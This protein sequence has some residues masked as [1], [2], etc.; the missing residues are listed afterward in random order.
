MNLT[1]KTKKAIKN[2]IF[3]EEGLEEFKNEP[4]LFKI[5]DCIMLVVIV[6]LIPILIYLMLLLISIFV[7]WIIL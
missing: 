6:L 5:V 1:N 4:L 3:D 2:I 7:Q